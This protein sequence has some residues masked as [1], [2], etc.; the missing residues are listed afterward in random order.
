MNSPKVSKLFRQCVIGSQQWRRRS[1]L[2]LLWQ[3]QAH[4][5]LRPAPVLS[6][7][8]QVTTARAKMYDIP[9]FWGLCQSSPISEKT[10]IQR[11]SQSHHLHFLFM[12]SIKNRIPC[13]SVWRYSLS[14]QALKT[15]HEPCLGAKYCLSPP[16]PKGQTGRH[17]R[18]KNLTQCLLQMSQHQ[19]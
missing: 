18:V 7:R 3:L 17:T 19:G 11:C 8:C 9:A 5:D 10:L 16:S 1:L 14:I 13:T 4:K 2:A 15:L 12:L 6:L